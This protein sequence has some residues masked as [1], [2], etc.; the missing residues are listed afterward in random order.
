MADGRWPMSD[1]R[2]PMADGRWPMADGRWPMADGRWGD[3]P[4][5][6]ALVS[7]RRDGIDTHGAAGGNRAGGER[8]GQQHESHAGERQWIGG[9]DAIEHRA[10]RPHQQHAA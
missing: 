4:W 8:G 6:T 7:E 10:E 2:W 3:G 1:G 9:L 5:P